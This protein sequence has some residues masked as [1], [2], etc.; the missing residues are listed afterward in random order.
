MSQLDSQHILPGKKTFS[1]GQHVILKIYIYI[2]LQVETLIKPMDPEARV[3]MANISLTRTSR[4]TTM[5]QDGSAWPMQVGRPVSSIY[6][7]Y[8]KQ[9]SKTRL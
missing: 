8:L 1:M 4:S 3:S 2:Y 5:D 7:T 6:Q 9:Y